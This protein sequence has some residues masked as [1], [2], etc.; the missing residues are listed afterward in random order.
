MFL[1]GLGAFVRFSM[2]Q[3]IGFESSERFGRVLEL[4]SERFQKVPNSSESKF[5]RF[6]RVA[7]VEQWH[8]TSLLGIPPELF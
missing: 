4:G 1:K 3:H 8:G 6:W 2:V 7:A 5:E